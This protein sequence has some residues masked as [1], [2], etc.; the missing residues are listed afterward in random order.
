MTSM[1][2]RKSHRIWPVM[3]WHWIATLAA[4]GGSAKLFLEHP[5]SIP[6]N[7]LA[8]FVAVWAGLSVIVGFRFHRN[9]PAR[10]PAIC[11]VHH[12]MKW[13]SCVIGLLSAIGAILASLDMWLVWS[14][15]L[16]RVFLPGI[17]VVLTITAVASGIV[18]VISRSVVRR[19]RELYEEL[20]WSGMSKE[21]K[22]E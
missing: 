21:R 12:V 15:G 10:L 13:S 9:G 4:T 18:F 11:R 20:E 7:S 22:M 8:A 5:A 3:T 14:D 16:G 1:R 6:Q 19:T 17:V 2:T